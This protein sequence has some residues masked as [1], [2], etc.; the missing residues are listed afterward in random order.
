MD[1]MKEYGRVVDVKGDIAMV[2]FIRTSACG[3]CHA[4]GMLSTQSEIVVAVPNTL[5][6][7]PGD[8]VAV[9]IRM[10]KALGASAIAY[11]FP[12]F[13]LILGAFIGWLLS[14][15]WGI[16]EGVD[17]TMALSAL[18]FAVLAFPLL[19]LARPLYSRRVSNVYTMADIKNSDE[20]S[21]PK[22]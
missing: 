4:C 7:Q 9:S 2:K 20:K 17:V 14:A 21:E 1:T 11:V 3:N 18:V 15:A 6:A 16:F 22:L 19:R 5:G 13:M 12:L 10:K 8:R